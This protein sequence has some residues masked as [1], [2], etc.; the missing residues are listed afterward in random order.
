MVLRGYRQAVRGAMGV[1]AGPSP[2]RAGTSHL[3]AESTVIVTGTEQGATTRAAGL[4]QQLGSSFPVS[5]SC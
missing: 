3:Q 5:V 4:E 2:S 1:V